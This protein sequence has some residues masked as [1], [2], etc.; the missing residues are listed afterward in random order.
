MNP[1]TLLLLRAFFVVVLAGMAAV[2]VW[3]SWHTPLFELPREVWTHPWFL[4]TLSD[5]Y[6]GFLT[7]YLWVAW[8]EPT[9]GA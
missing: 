5:A 4:A 8:K 2:T 1:S 6:F 7:F 9:A 3:A